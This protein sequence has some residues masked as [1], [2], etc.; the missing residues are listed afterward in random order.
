MPCMKKIK[1]LEY[2]KDDFKASSS[3]I[4]EMDGQLQ[5]VSSLIGKHLRTW[6]DNSPIPTAYYKISVKDD[7]EPPGAPIGLSGTCDASGKIQLIW[8][9]PSDPDV[10]GYR[11]FT[12]YNETGDILERTTE[13]VNDTMFTFYE[14]IKRNNKFI[15]VYVQALD[16]HANNSEMAK[17][18]VKIYDIVPPSAPQL[19]HVGQHPYGFILDVKSSPDDEVEVYKN[20]KK[21]RQ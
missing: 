4:Q 17:N 16:Y 19:L 18:K 5:P 7:T 8:T 10:R 11:V 3:F 20:S 1:W 14:D 12:S 13:P 6:S 21:T 2:F 15:H 9:A